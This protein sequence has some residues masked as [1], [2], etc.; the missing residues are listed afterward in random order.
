[1]SGDFLQNLI[2]RHLG[3]E[4][5]LQPRPTS[6]FETANSVSNAV[7]VEKNLEATPESQNLQAASALS[8]GPNRESRFDMF[9]SEYVGRERQAKVDS[10]S[11][12]CDIAS[13]LKIEPK[14]P[15]VQQDLN[16]NASQES[17]T[18][19]QEQNVEPLSVSAHEAEIL[20]SEFPSPPFSKGDRKRDSNQFDI[21]EL[22]ELFGREKRI[23]V[24]EESSDKRVADTPVAPQMPSN[25]IVLPKTSDIFDQN[26]GYK[27]LAEVVRQLRDEI[28]SEKETAISK[29]RDEQAL[30]VPPSSIHAEKPLYSPT[31]N[32]SFLGEPN[33]PER[34]TKPEPVINVT[35]GR[36]EVRAVQQPD[37]P[38]RKRQQP[39]GVMSLDDYLHKRGG[40]NS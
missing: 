5:T 7:G 18:S 28:S 1:M 4:P 40:G 21:S 6:R 23:D 15:D 20:S 38:K 24:I 26:V 25:N 35:I 11:I 3:L 33:I 16:L 39:S 34:E 10:P 31:V 37:P 12:V 27:E 9:T 13:E 29:T 2:T 17:T 14:N 36:V 22:A 32:N 30:I 19:H 8:D